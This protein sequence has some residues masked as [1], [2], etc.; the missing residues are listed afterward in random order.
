MLKIAEISVKSS[1]HEM[2]L[3][4]KLGKISKYAEI[5]HDTFY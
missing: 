1:F 2:M 5:Y 4:V 3:K